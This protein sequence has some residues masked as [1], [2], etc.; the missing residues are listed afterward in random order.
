MEARWASFYA[1]LEDARRLWRSARY[2]V[3]LSVIGLIRLIPRRSAAVLGGWLGGGAFWA[4]TRYRKRSI[5]NIGVAFPAADRRWIRW[6]AQSSMEGLGAGFVE[7]LSLAGIGPDGRRALA[8]V[9]GEGH[10]A[11]AL[12]KGRGAVVLSGHLGCWEFL[13]AYLAALGLRT[14]V[15][16]GP[17]AGA[18]ETELLRRERERLGV[19]EIMPEVGSLR[20]AFRTLFEG[21]VIVCPFDRDVGE[22]GCNVT[23]LGRSVALPSLPL[24][25]ARAARSAVLP[26]YTSRTGSGHSVVF[27][28]PVEIGE[29]DNIYE[30]AFELASTVERWIR[31]TPEQWTWM[32]VT[33]HES[34]GRK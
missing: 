3:Y 24:R 26:A 15:V 18:W 25:L 28:K 6:V 1:G 14:G 33:G 30:I 4:L 5:E 13:P 19:A 21:G 16:A 32:D 12:D 8:E 2:L 34:S 20:M 23:F 11:S 22:G 17:Q 29:R 27:E 31:G 7:A 9:S 10:L